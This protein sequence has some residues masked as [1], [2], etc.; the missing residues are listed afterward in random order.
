MTRPFIRLVLITTDHPVRLPVE[1]FLVLVIET[2]KPGGAADG[3]GTH[4]VVH[5]SMVPAFFTPLFPGSGRIDPGLVD[6]DEFGIR[7]GAKTRLARS[8]LQLPLPP[9]ELPEI[10]Q[11]GIEYR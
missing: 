3:P 9:D 11:L 2:K 6:P 1:A 5:M 10:P 4:H 8:F 7:Q